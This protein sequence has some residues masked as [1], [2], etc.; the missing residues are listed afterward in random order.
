MGN[1]IEGLMIILEKVGTRTS[2]IGLAS[3]QIST[4]CF[5][6]LGFF[7]Y[8]MLGHSLALLF[9][10]VAD[11][12]F[13][14]FMVP[15][16]DDLHFFRRLA[17]RHNKRAGSGIGN[18]YLIPDIEAVI[19]KPSA[20]YQDIRISIRRPEEGHAFRRRINPATQ[21]YLSGIFH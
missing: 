17:H 7:C 2:T 1:R 19:P 15:I 11:Q 12:G 13:H 14:F 10:K 16:S 8:M 21:H 9:S 6:D 5:P 3:R 4:E 20:F 18:R